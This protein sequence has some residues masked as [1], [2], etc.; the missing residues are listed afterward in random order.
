KVERSAYAGLP[1]RP[2]AT[3][4]LQAEARSNLQSGRFKAYLVCSSAPGGV[5]RTGPD[6]AGAASPND[7]AWHALR[8]GVQCPGE[9][10]Q[11]VVALHNPGLG[12]VSFRDLRVLEVAPSR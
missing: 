2:N 8:I 6:A 10:Q 5:V 11:L 1:A 7:G 12:K 4:V 3:Y 9:A